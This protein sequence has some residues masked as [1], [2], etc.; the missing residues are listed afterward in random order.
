MQRITAASLSFQN[1]KIKPKCDVK[2]LG[3]I[4]D[5]GLTWEKNASNVRQKAYLG[6]NKIKRVSSTLNNDTKRLLINALVYPHLNYCVNTWSNTLKHVLNRFDSL[7]RQID[8]D[9]PMN[10][11][12]NS[13]RAYNSAMMTFKAVNKICPPYLSKRFI[14]CGN[15]GDPNA[16]GVQTRAGAEKKLRLQRIRNKFDSKTFLHNATTVWNNLP[17]D[18]RKAKSLVTFKSK[19]KSHF[20]NN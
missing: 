20:F 9:V 8:R 10:R 19:A 2:Y 18:L 1:A 15:G 4:F 6:L 14:L 11:P 12:F 13:L 7:T 5:E 17:D 16:T 3:V